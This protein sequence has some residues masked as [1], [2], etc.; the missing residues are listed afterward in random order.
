MA[1]RGVEKLQSPSLAEIDWSRNWTR[2]ALMKFRVSFTCNIIILHNAKLKKLRSLLFR[3]LR[4]WFYSK[5]MKWVLFIG[6]NFWWGILLS[7][8][9][10]RMAMNLW[11]VQGSLL[12]N[13]AM[14]P[15]FMPDYSKDLS[16][17]FYKGQLILSL[18]T[19]HHIGLSAFFPHCFFII[20]DDLALILNYND[21]TAHQANFG[22]IPSY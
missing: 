2:F 14:E 1:S 19:V 8:F 7:D 16:P 21:L 6:Q 4:F 10:W 22:I 13:L 9:W 3:T 18:E 5:L 20:K 17:D 12:K 11:L 15:L